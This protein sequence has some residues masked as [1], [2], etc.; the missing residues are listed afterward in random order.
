MW[1]VFLLLGKG[2]S[3][4]EAFIKRCKFLAMCINVGDSNGLE[5]MNG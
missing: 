2:N 4:K 3:N 1:E 5:F